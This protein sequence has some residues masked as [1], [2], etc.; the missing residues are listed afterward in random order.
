MQNPTLSRIRRG[1]AV[2]VILAAGGAAAQTQMEVI[3][4]RY[5]TADQI[6]PALQPFLDRSGTLSGYQNQLIVRT[7][8]QNL[9]ELRQILATLDAM[10]RR[11]QIT[12]T[13]DAD[14][15]RERSV[16]EASGSFGGDR[17]RVT[18]PPEPGRPTGAIVQGGSGDD[19][20]RARVDSGVSTG[21]QRGTQ[22]VQ[23]LEGNEASIRVGQSAPVP[24]R[25]VRRTVVNGQ[26]VEQVVDSAQIVEA[27][28]GFRV[29]PRVSGS[30]VTLEIMPQAESFSPRQPGAVNVQSA[31]T[32]VSG[33]LG[34][35]IE[36]G[37][38]AT[39]SGERQ[40]GLA[41]RRESNVLDS[42]RIFLKVDEVR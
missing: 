40:S 32:V 3:P 42:R 22:T 28:T 23:V 6:I 18:I 8:P 16:A 15:L 5:R 29:R 17:G 34:E 21:S 7:T 13:Q 35:W 4:L 26:V 36:V 1:I 20:F 19:R 30:Q 37:G 31:S 41:S 10:P 33:R 25:S 39:Q 9:A 27:N 12:V 24:T 38:S 14:V 2:L 11:L